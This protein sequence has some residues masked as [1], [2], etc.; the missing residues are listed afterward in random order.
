[1]ST[2]Y[3]WL[4]LPLLLLPAPLLFASPAEEIQSIINSEEPAGVVFD[5]IS[6]DE[7]YLREALPAI[8]G[9]IKTLR[10]KFPELAIAVVTH[11]REQFALQKQIKPA[12]K[13]VHRQVQSL[14]A[15][16]VPVHVCATHAG[17]RGVSEEDFP[18]YVDVAAAGP[19][20]VNDYVSLG[21]IKIILSDD[22]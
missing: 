22:D 9:Y 11:G 4:L 1:M 14:L 5:V 3:R 6:G 10:N 8:Q 16:D 17:W 2:V 7:D 18:D 20:Q 15:D 19:A 21:Y 13:K 12:Y